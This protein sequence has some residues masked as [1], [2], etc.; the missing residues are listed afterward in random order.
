MNIKIELGKIERKSVKEL[1]SKMGSSYKDL[2]VQVA[3]KE[4]YNAAKD[5]DNTALL[6]LVKRVE[7][8][9]KE[10]I[11]SMKASKEEIKAS[12][13]AHEYGEVSM[14][15]IKNETLDDVRSHLDEMLQTGSK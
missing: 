2:S 10:K 1:L 12:K 4:G 9:M 6:T 15:E 7:E 3:Y 13:E 11:E 5:E 8:E 14:M